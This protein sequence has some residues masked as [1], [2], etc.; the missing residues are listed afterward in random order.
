MSV[1]LR[2]KKVRNFLKFVCVFLSLFIFC[3]FSVSAEGTINA[4]EQAILEKLQTVYK[5]G[6]K[7][8]IIPVEYV[9]QA[10]NF[11]LTVSVTEAQSDEIIGYIENGIKILDSQVENFGAG[12]VNFDRFEHSAKAE[13]LT[14]GQKATQVVGLKLVYSCGLVT[15][16]DSAGKL[17]FS[18]AAIIKVTGT[19][20]RHLVFGAVTFGVI[21]ATY[22]TCLFAFRKAKENNA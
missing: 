19:S 4:P 14:L 11:F 9:N 6:D 1:I 8:Y 15:I 7:E 13:I 21:A 22:V 3:A 2:R 17:V 12:D 10:R 20:S 18:G 16:T 5:V